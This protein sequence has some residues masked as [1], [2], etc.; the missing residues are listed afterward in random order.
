M[1]AVA[2]RRDF[3]AAFAACGEAVC[4]CLDGR[5]LA[6]MV[7]SRQQQQA[8]AQRLPETPVA[9]GT[10]Y[11]SPSLESA[12]DE[13]LA[14]CRSPVVVLPLY[15][16]YS[17]STVGAV[18]SRLARILA[19]KLAF[20][21]IVLFVITPITTIILMHWRTAYVRSFCQTWRTGS[22]VALLSWH[23]PALCR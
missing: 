9:L 5:W 20:R 13:L 4:L 15:H 18:W 7:Y 12:V 17:C 1:V 22:A 10:G 3:T 16:Q 2:A 21:D 6:M 14:T 8:L 19:R 23:S 11:G